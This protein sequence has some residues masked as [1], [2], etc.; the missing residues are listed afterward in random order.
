MAESEMEKKLA[1]E[2]GDLRILFDR[3]VAANK[4]RESAIH[5][6]YIIANISKELGLDTSIPL[7]SNSVEKLKNDV[8]EKFGIEE[9]DK[10]ISGNGLHPVWKKESYKSATKLFKKELEDI[11]RQVGKLT[12]AISKKSS[13][14]FTSLEGRAKAIFDKAR[15]G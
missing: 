12:G 5:A 14:D 4:K 9:N 7:V 2:L 13:T 6:D 8:V 11:K 3:E 10:L 1:M 15:K